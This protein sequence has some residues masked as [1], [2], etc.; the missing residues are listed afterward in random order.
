MSE[1]SP[2]RIL[3]VGDYPDDPRLGS[4]KVLVKLQEQLR[5]AGHECDVLL[6]N[7][8]GRRP[9]GRQLRQL[10]SP[11]L[12]GHAIR[13]AFARGRYDVIDASSAEGLW[14]G[15][16]RR[17]RL[18]P[19]AAL[20]CRSHGIEHLNYR[21]T[22]EDSEAGLA[23]K[24]WSRRVW[25][26]VSR[27]SQVALAARV[28]DRMIVLTE[29]ER[30]FALTRG[31]QAADRVHVVPHGVSDLFLNGTPPPAASGASVLFCGTWTHSKG[32]A[33][34]VKAVET[35][36]AKGRAVPL[37]VLGPGV[38]AREVLEAF[39][40]QARAHVSVI[41]RMPEDRVLEEYRRHDIFVLP[42]TYEGFGMVLLE[43]M[44]QGV[45][46]IATPTGCAPDLIDDGETGLLVPARDVSAL[47]AAIERLLDDSELR[48]RLGVNAVGSL[49][50][51]SW[52][53][54]VARTLDV[55]R[56]AIQDARA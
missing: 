9:A 11:L 4:T 42:S 51:V 36:V 17:A 45:A 26:P 50:G 13:R 22:L 19:R 55:Y 6:E 39:S 18:A 7:A 30:Q 14:F 32:I 44:T 34:L 3:L 49:H 21:R 2:L 1:T 47:A 12:A 15:F 8:L 33:Y 23:P 29:R 48:R 35:L 54:T 27:L 46:A 41:D 20:I 31:W 5:A 52:R 24:P 40:P 10:V 38:N 53:D 43:A 37:T 56:L 16:A 25:Y 28:A